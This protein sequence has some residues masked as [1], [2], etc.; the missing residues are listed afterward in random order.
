M[1]NDFVEDEGFLVKERD[2]PYSTEQK[3]LLIGSCKSLID[4]ARQVG[5]PVIYARVFLRPDKLDSALSVRSDAARIDRPY[6]VEGTW[7]AQI[8]TDLTP[9]PDDL[10]IT[11]KGNSAFAFTHLDRLLKN[12][13][14]S[15][16]VMIGGAVYGCVNASLRDASALGYSSY[17]VPEAM[18]P[19]GDPSCELLAGRGDLVSVGQAKEVLAAAA[20]QSY[21]YAPT[22]D[23]HDLADQSCLLMIDLQNDF[24]KRGGALA[25]PPETFDEPAYADILAKNVQLMRWA[26][27]E[28]LPVICVRAVT[29][30]DETD[31]AISRKVRG[32]LGVAA[33]ATMCTVDTWGAE[34]AAEVAPRA[35]LGDIELIKKGH[36]AFTFT[37][38]NRMLTNLGVKQCLVTG[39]AIGGCVEETIRE[40]SAHGYSMVAVSDACYRPG[41]TRMQLLARTTILINTDDV[42][43]T[44]ASTLAYAGSLQAVAG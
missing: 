23:W 38:L 4:Q 41:D 3:S 36:S 12:M 27:A 19:V 20:G 10:I 15:S 2:E 43:S 29:R 30:A 11:K 16:L 37:H 14:V 22:A 32:R 26:R 44:S 33:D 28:G 39:G 9:L 34:F 21:A 13:G 25:G 5:A 18:Y 31:S 35:E 42:V 40:G 8:V 1:Q 17:V 7:G 6:L 24:V